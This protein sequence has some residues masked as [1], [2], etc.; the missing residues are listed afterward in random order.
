MN[1]RFMRK[2]FYILSLVAVGL[3]ASIYTSKAWAMECVNEPDDHLKSWCANIRGGHHPDA[4]PKAGEEGI[5]S[6]TRGW[7]DEQNNIK[8]RNK[9]LKKT[10]KYKDL[11]IT[12]SSGEGLA[13]FVNETGAVV[14]T[15]DDSH[16]WEAKQKAG[17]GEVDKSITQEAGWDY[18][19]FTCD[20]CSADRK[21]ETGVGENPRFSLGTSSSPCAQVDR[22]LSTDKDGGWQAVSLCDPSCSGGGY[23]TPSY[24][25]PGNGKPEKGLECE[26]LK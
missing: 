11:Q 20:R 18:I 19:Y 16:S 25:T 21:C 1:K 6:R 23:T 26:G 22:R 12:D 15:S 5:T 9:V 7:Q 10:E 17:G 14:P 3:A 24:P 2:L 4:P 8:S 13:V